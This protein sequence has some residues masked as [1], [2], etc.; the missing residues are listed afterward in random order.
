MHEQLGTSWHS[1][2]KFRNSNQ[3]LSFNICHSAHMG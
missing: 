3:H 1:I 2:I